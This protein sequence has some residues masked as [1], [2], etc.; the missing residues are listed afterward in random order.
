MNIEKLMQDIDILY[1]E[2]KIDEVEA[3]IQEK[4]VEIKENNAIY[5]AISLM[6]EL[7]GIYREKGDAIKG[8]KTVDEILEIFEQNNL[9]HDENYGTSLLNIATAQRSFGNYEVA[10]RYY[11]ECKQCYVGKIDQNDYRYASLYN[12]IS[13]LSIETKDFHCAIENLK[14]SLE[15]LYSHQNVDVQIATA[16]TSLAQIYIEMDCLEIAKK[17]IKIAMNIFKNH[18]DYHFSAT[19]AVGAN[20]E[21]LMKNYKKSAELYKKAMK[22]IEK[23]LGKTENYKI[24]EENLRSVEEY[25]KPS[26]LDICKEYYEE[27]GVSMIASKFEKFEKKIAVGMVGQGS[28]CFEFDDNF[29]KDHDFGVGFCMWLTDDV[30]EKI[31]ADLQKEYDELPKKYKNIDKIDAKSGKRDGVFKISDFYCELIGFEK[32]PITDF[33][34]ASIENYELAHATNGLV[35][36]DDLRAFSRVRDSLKSQY[37]KNVWAK[38]IAEKA[39]E[40]SQKGQY[41]FGRML[42]RGD[43]VTARII[44]SEFMLNSMELMLM[45]NQN[46]PPFYK[47]VHKKFEMLSSDISFEEMLKLPIDD[48]EN[49]KIIEKIVANII[50]ELKNKGFIQEISQNNFLDSYVYEIANSYDDTSEKEKLV[51]KTVIY[52][53]NAFDKVQGIDGRAS[54]QDDFETFTIMRSSQFL[55]WDNE[56][57]RSYI[58]DFEQALDVGRNLVTE[59]YAFMMKSTDIENFRKIESNLPEITPEK[60]DLIEEIIK[61]QLKLVFEI[62]PKYPK[63]VSNGRSIKSQDDSLY[64]TSYETYLRGELSTYSF[65]TVELYNKMIVENNEK[66]INTAKRYMENVA[67]Q[68]GYKDLESA[69]ENLQ[70]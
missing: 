22:E 17:H 50:I 42:K 19:L 61:K 54:C 53:W 4:I 11:N 35:F 44:L 43:F 66:G 30:Y 12:N 52:E 46:Y 24:L 5:P 67:F 6:N 65:K 7:L 47:W 40:V 70:I 57:I 64:N 16:N 62:Q 23:Y 60:S 59:K 14:K 63:F 29:S 34:W 48:K 55:A 28:Q 15:I 41:N 58:S 3:L 32:A 13:L 1:S 37:P 69:E 20:I 8:Q 18:E 10:K 38:K 68:Y 49:L 45:I 31:G 9:K 51:Q 25:I 26:T 33:E 21:F 56:L 36:R 39:H 2:Q 27:F